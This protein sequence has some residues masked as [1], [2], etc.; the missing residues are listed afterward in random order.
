MSWSAVVL[1]SDMAHRAQAEERVVTERYVARYTESGFVDVSVTLHGPRW[2]VI[3]EVL[4]VLQHVAASD[5]QI[6]T[7]PLV[8]WLKTD[9]EGYLTC[10]TLS[11][12]WLVFTVPEI[13]NAF[14]WQRDKIA[15]TQV[16]P[17]LPYEVDE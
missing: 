3:K 9:P 7:G 4:T 17:Y 2:R 8:L 15:Q 13:V 1:L 16:P 5:A 12:W 11:K 14:E 10:F 6:G